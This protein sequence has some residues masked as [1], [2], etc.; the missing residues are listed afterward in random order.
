VTNPSQRILPQIVEEGLQLLVDGTFYVHRVLGSEVRELVQGPPEGRTTFSNEDISRISVSINHAIERLQKYLFPPVIQ[1]ETTVDQQKP[2]EQTSTA[3]LFLPGILFMALLFMGEGLS[4]DVWRERDGG[5]LRRAACAPSSVAALL[6]GKLLASTLVI[7]T[8]ALVVLVAGM[9]YLD[10]SLAILP[11]G[12]VWASLSGVVFLLLFLLIQMHASS[13]RA[14]TVL[15]NS[16]LM[17][18]LFVGGSMFP[19]EAMPEW[20]AG[21]GRW[22]PNGWALMHLRDIL[23][24]RSDAAQ[25]GVA[26]MALL[27]ISAALFLLT[28]RRMRRV[29]ARS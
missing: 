24:D 9:L 18:L 6:A 16:L 26:F 7:F 11:L 21:I 25:L 15:T 13:Q 28:E 23:F 10:M 19:F 14:A 20:M 17:P 27:L 3:K 2:G 1:L 12:L 29:F 8:S 22:T 5:T 4:A